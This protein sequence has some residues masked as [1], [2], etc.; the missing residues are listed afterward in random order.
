MLLLDRSSLVYREN[1]AFFCSFLGNGPIIS[2]AAA[3]DDILSLHCNGT[4]WQ[5]LIPCVVAGR[6]TSS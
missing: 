2:S 4:Y 6:L 1:D 5:S 3:L